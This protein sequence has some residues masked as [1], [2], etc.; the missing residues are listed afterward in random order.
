MTKRPLVR[1]LLI[2]LGLALLVALPSLLAGWR[3]LAQAR[4]APEQLRA[5]AQYEQAAGRLPWRADLLEQAGQSALAAANPREAARLFAAADNRNALSAGGLISYGDTLWVLSQSAAALAQW[6]RAEVADPQNPALEKRLAA[7]YETQGNYVAARKA[8]TQAAELVPA[9]ARAQH[10]LA[11]LLAASQPELSLGHFERA[12][13][14]DPSLEPSLRPLLEAL[15]KAVGEATPA[16]RLTEAGRALSAAGEL[17][18]SEQALQAALTLE[19]RSPGALA[20]L[21]Q[22]RESLGEDGLAEMQTALE[23]APR[24]PQMQI[25]MGLFWLRRGEEKL[26]LPHFA[27][28]AALDP[29]SPLTQA[30]HADALART[31]DLAGAYAAYERATAL[32]PEDADYWRLLANFCV[33]Y[34]YDV[35][36]TGLSAALKAQAFAP[37]DYETLI[38]L[39][40]VSLAQGEFPTAE[41]FFTRAYNADSTLP[42]AP[43][44]LAI[45]ALEQGQRELARQY[46][47]HVLLIDPAGPYG[48]RARLL[49]ERYFSK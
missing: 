14:L 8:L 35:E 40:R 6:Q 2:T 34:G 46:V 24:D 17:V 47:D 27:K 23:M 7:A 42:A 12:M 20:L 32:A 43:L 25:L 9:D 26:G 3:D 31:G 4:A 13:V 41:R 21:G 33:D 44:Y 30:A 10:R 22:V 15:N 11:L 29:Q 19:P 1:I 18:L 49:L 5:S 16:A 37:K 28:A 36:H 48:G 45:V 38:T 39:G